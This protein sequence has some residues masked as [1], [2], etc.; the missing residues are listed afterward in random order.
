MEPRTF[1]SIGDYGIVGDLWA[2]P[3]RDLVASLDVRGRDAVDLATGT[4]V[5]A[6]ALARGG[7]ASVV[8]VDVTPQLLTEAARRAEAEDLDIRWLEADVTDVPLP[9]ASADVVTSTFGLVFA[10]DPVRAVGEARR[11]ARP[12]GLVVF[13]SW[14]PNGLF[15]EIRQVMSRYFPDVPT[16]WHETVDGI[17]G[18]TGTEDVVEERE[19]DLVIDSPEAFVDLMEHYSAPVVLAS[20]ALGDRWRDARKDLVAAVTSGTTSTGRECLSRVPYFVTTL[21]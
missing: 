21:A 20:Q 7:A 1:W 9:S 2:A 11:M 16:P 10:E 14:S 18:V 5:T 12:E 6:I 19:F 13:T 3:G 17:R 8:G 15:G 4:G